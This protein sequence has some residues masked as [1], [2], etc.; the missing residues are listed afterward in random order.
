MLDAMADTSTAL[1]ALES[2]INFTIMFYAD[3]RVGP[4]GIL[5]LDDR[6]DDLLVRYKGRDDH[7]WSAQEKAEMMR[8]VMK[9]QETKLQQHS[10][11]SLSS[12]QNGDIAVILQT[13]SSYPID[14]NQES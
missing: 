12:I 10:S 8:S 6:I 5:S 4:H 14:L 2:D 11:T 3:F 9:N 1:A 13:L 7:F